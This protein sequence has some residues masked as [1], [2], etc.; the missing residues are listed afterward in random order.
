MTANTDI[1]P[2]RVFDIAAAERSTKNDTQRPFS[3]SE[4]TALRIQTANQLLEKLQPYIEASDGLLSIH[5]NIENFQNTPPKIRDQKRNLVVELMAKSKDRS[6][7]MEI[8]AMMV[9]IFPPEQHN[10]V[11]IKIGA[12]T[13]YKG[14]YE[15]E[16]VENA[17]GAF[18]KDVLTP[19]KQYDMRQKIAG[20]QLPVFRETHYQP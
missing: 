1:N 2:T 5:E 9:F 13:R 4:I 7:R 15:M 10:Q 19:E 3:S 12:D 16:K 6:S 17:L 18:F 11:L 20:A 8:T 14:D